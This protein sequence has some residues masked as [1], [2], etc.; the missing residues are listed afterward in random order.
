MDQRQ[1]TADLARRAVTRLAPDELAL[2]EVTW[3]A[4]LAAPARVRASG[5]RQD[6]MIG[7]GVDV[8]VPLVTA[9]ALTASGA[10]LQII[11][12]RAGESFGRRILGRLRRPLRRGPQPSPR[13]AVEL[14]PETIVEIRRV[15]H[16]QALAFDLSEEQAGLLADAILGGL[17]NPDR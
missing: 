15:A 4:Y 6:D 8:V 10:A 3:P 7:F 12:G 16:R 14:P 11:A 13:G 1:R 9:A 2:F 5:R 17:L